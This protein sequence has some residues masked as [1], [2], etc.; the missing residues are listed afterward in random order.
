MAGLIAAKRGPEAALALRRLDAARH[1]ARRELD[2]F[3]RMASTEQ[4]AVRHLVAFNGLLGGTPVAGLN[5]LFRTELE[6]VGLSGDASRIATLLQQE[7]PL[8]MEPDGKASRLG[9]IQPD[10]IGEGVIVEA[11]ETAPP[12]VRLEGAATVQRAYAQSPTAAAMAL[13]RLLQ[14]YA[15]AL[16]D[17]A[18][19][20]PE[21]ETAKML[22]GWLTTL[23]ATIKNPID[24]E[25]L[26][27]ALPVNSLILREQA[28]D[29]TEKMADARRAALAASGKAEDTVLAAMWVNNLANRQSTLG[30]RDEALTTAKE[31]VVLYRTLAETQPDAF[32][33]NLAGTLNTLASSLSNLGKRD[34]AL[35]AAKEAVTIY[36]T[37]AEAQRD[38]FKP[39]LAV[40]L[41]TLASSLSSLGKHDE[42]L[43]AAK[44]A[45]TLYR[46]LAETQ[47]DAFKPNFAMSLTNLATR[48][49]DLGKHDEALAAAEEAVTIRRA[50][51][52][53]RPD[54][55][56]PDLATSLNN[57]ANTLSNLDKHEKAL[58]AAGEAV[59]IQCA[60][61]AS[62]VPQQPCE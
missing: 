4:D 57:F 23:V 54:A 16:E 60:L 1:L 49:S 10:L 19:S 40:S 7:L 58:V 47:P 6:T 13:M 44:E 35:A 43:A 59:T 27:L 48:L 62:H 50:L 25:P 15:Y 33:P 55:F 2:R 45:V 17:A 42:A 31:A 37:F 38:S 61:A 11:F 36:R 53:D 8:A 46:T 41:N 26:V 18:A 29:L 5:S 20:E 56:K 21:R 12:A 32:K 9:T 34:E 52:D 14:D 22:M 24:L 30:K 39:T 28:L 51:A 3:A